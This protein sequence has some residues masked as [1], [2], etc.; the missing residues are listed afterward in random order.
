[1]IRIDFSLRNPLKYRPWQNIWQRAWSV[2]AHRTLEVCI[3]HYAY[4]IVSF[5]LDLG[6]RG[7]D[8][9][10]PSF[11]LRLFG[12]GFNISLPDNRHWNYATNSWEPS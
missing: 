1:M 11:G 2:S 10:G 12:L 3:D 4:D 8:H 5:E 9:A 7:S 6:W